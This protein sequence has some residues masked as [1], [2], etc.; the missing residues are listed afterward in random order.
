MNNFK[1][2]LL[3]GQIQTKCNRSGLRGAESQANGWLLC[4]MYS[5]WVMWLVA[6]AM[7]SVTATGLPEHWLVATNR[8]IEIEQRDS[9]PSRKVLLEDASQTFVG[10]KAGALK[11]NFLVESLL[12]Y[13]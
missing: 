12:K 3:D 2:P 1:T 10:S 13:T 7:V 9:N 5:L 11:G 4:W 8:S 6:A